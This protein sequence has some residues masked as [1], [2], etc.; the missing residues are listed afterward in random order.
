MPSYYAAPAK[1]TNLVRIDRQQDRHPA[2]D[3]GEGH[4]H[5]PQLGVVERRRGER[6]HPVKVDTGRGVPGPRVEVLADLRPRNELQNF[7]PRT[8][9]TR[10]PLR[11][12]DRRRR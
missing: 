5:R 12:R 3:R 10:H 9:P 11:A 7:R 4:G 6:G 2:A 1:Q 8:I